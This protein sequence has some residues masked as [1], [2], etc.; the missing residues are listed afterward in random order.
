M[1]R[2]LRL[3]L[4]AFTA[5]VSFMTAELLL[6]VLFGFAWVSPH[7]P[8]SRFLAGLHGSPAEG[9]IYRTSRDPILGLEFVP[10]SRQ[11][12][13]RINKDGFRGPEVA[14]T[15]APG[16]VRIAVLGDSEAF[17]ALLQ[18]DET[19]SGCLKRGLDREAGPARHEVLN[20]GFPGYNTRQELQVLMTRAIDTRPALVVLYVVLNDMI[21]ESQSELLT[22]SPASHSYAC[23]FLTYLCRR[24]IKSDYEKLA[25]SDLAGFYKRLHAAG[26]LERVK[27]DIRTMSRFLSDRRIPLLV[28]ISPDI[29]GYD[30]FANYPYREIHRDLQ[31]LGSEQGLA[32]EIVDPIDALA[33]LGRSPRQLWVDERDSH[34]SAL[35]TEAIARVVVPRIRKLLAPGG[36]R[37]ITAAS[38]GTPPSAPGRPGSPTPARTVPDRPGPSALP[39]PG[40]ASPAAR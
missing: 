38:P 40:G 3:L 37:P 26:H 31:R 13:I 2:R 22:R 28:V 24:W 33:G 36:T 4:I 21:A 9:S 32:V 14:P 12:H 17:G 27:G 8:F 11:R 35:A 6:R 1:S 23:L 30:D 29:I 7:H 19:L 39:V 10:G 18:E 20:F 25:E 5:L 34:K 16:T 15:P